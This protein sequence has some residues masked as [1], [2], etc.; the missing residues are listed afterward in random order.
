MAQ[1]TSDRETAADALKTAR[2]M[3]EKEKQCYWSTK[4]QFKNTENERNSE[5]IPVIVFIL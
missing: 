1:Q 4:I 3:E 5:Q 2:P